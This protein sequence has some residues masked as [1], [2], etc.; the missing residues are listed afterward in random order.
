HRQRIVAAVHT[1]ARG[2]LQEGRR[3]GSTPPE[4]AARRQVEGTRF[5]GPCE[6]LRDALLWAFP[7][8]PDPFLRFRASAANSSTKGEAELVLHL[9]DS[10]MV[11]KA[12][13]KC[14]PEWV[15]QSAA[16][17]EISPQ[18]TR[19]RAKFHARWARMTAAER[20]RRYETTS[21]FTEAVDIAWRR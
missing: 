10:I 12:G 17:V 2:Y 3:R 20:I 8:L 14:A 1:I 16:Y 19:W 7:D 9:L 15:R 6:V 4:V 18:R 5:G 21:I 13:E 11:R